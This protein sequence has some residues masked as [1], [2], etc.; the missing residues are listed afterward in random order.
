MYVAAVVPLETPVR[1]FYKEKSIG[2][3]VESGEPKQI[4]FFKKRPIK[5]NRSSRQ[6]TDDDN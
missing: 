2:S 3:L 6:R 4:E 1:K 5:T